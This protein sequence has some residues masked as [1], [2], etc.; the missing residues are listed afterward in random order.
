MDAGIRAGGH[1]IIIGGPTPEESPIL[2]RPDL[3]SFLTF[4]QHHPSLSYF[5]S[6][7]FVGPTS[8]AP[9]I[10]EA[11]HET[12]YELEIAFSQLPKSGKDFPL[13]IDSSVICLSI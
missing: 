13:S 12:L 11:R 2:R 3:Q 1:H 4:W 7:L 8:Q 6:G 9:R 5:F 10:D